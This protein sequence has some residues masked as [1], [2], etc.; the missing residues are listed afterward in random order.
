[1]SAPIKVKQKLTKEDIEKQLLA[2]LPKLS[3][4][5]YSSTSSLVVDKLLGGGVP[6]GATIFLW[7]TPNS[8]K[9]TFVHLIMAQMIRENKKVLYVPTEKYDLLYLLN[10][11]GLPQ[12]ITDEELRKYIWIY[13]KNEQETT[14]NFMLKV[15]QHKFV[16]TIV[17]DS[18]SA[19]VPMDL[20]FEAAD[21][22]FGT[23]AKINN[24]LLRRLPKI[25]SLQ[26]MSFIFTGQVRQEMGVTNYVSYIVPGGMLAMRHASS[27]ELQF[28]RSVNSPLKGQEN[29]DERL[30]FEMDI[31]VISA[32]S[33]GCIGG[34]KA[35]PVVLVQDSIP[36]I[37][38]GS[39]IL[40]I[41]DIYG[42]FS[43]K[44]GNPLIGDVNAL[45]IRKW[46]DRVLGNY[47][48]A[49]EI[50]NNDLDLLE[51]LYATIRQAIIHSN[52]A[53]VVGVPNSFDE[54]EIDE[55]EL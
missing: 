32:R 1:M 9:T 29:K 33:V 52:T 18:I 39:E 54:A 55:D 34:S 36:R 8:G 15:A 47:Q 23:S 6:S 44:D 4:A 46:K 31:T 28:K 14:V 38:N 5:S 20:M 48:S 21:G 16:D 11:L 50:I 40:E 45:S 49:R 10:A 2:E 25:C 17:L 51:E 26:N 24:I 43:D 35:N 41:G 37:D 27:I 7:G 3:R 12:D 19:F 30:A 13:P 53:K 22:Q 42:L